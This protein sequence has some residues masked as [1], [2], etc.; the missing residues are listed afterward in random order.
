MKLTRRFVQVE[1]VLAALPL[2]L[3]LILATSA[4]AV[5]FTEI[6]PNQWED[7][8]WGDLDWAD[9]DDEYSSGSTALGFSVVLGGATY[10]HFDINSNG[11]VELLTSAADSPADYGYGDVAGLIDYDDTST[12]L[13]AAYDDLTSEYY[14]YFGYKLL[15]DRAV[16]YYD[17]ET[18]E[19]E[20]YEYLNTFEIILFDDG[21]VQWNFQWADYDWYGYDLFS[22]LYFGNTE[23]LLELTSDEIP[24]QESYLYSV[25]E[26]ATLSLLTMGGLALLRR[27]K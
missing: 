11:Y 23:T 5:D 25:P 12:Y 18:Y 15:P 16:F 10:S 19:D 4:G 13:M 3:I 2:V 24:E 7:Y 6:T 17:T 9:Y 20:D 21:S 26:P 1:S 22:G 14:G 8:S 27:R